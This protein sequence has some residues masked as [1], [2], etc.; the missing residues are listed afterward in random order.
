MK[1]EELEAAIR[2]NRKMGFSHEEIQEIQLATKTFPVD[3]IWDS[4]TVEAVAAWQAANG[5]K[6]DGKVGPS[7]W[8][9]MSLELECVAPGPSQ[10]PEVETGVGCGLAAY[11]IVFPGHTAA[12]SLGTALSS[13]LAEDVSEIRYWSSEWLIDDLGNKGT[14]H[15]EPFL[16]S[17][18]FSSDLRIGA[19][20]DDPISVLKKPVYTSRLASMGI[21]AG[22]LMINRSNTRKSDAPWVLR[23]RN[24]DDLKRVAD[25]FETR[26]IE[27]IATTW[28]RPSKAMIDRMC[29]DMTRIMAL[30]GAVAFEVDTEGNWKPKHLAGFRTMSEAAHYLAAAMRRAIVDAGLEAVA[31]TELTTYTYHTENSAKAVL[32]PLLDFLLPQGYAVRHR[33]HDVIEWDDSLGP[34]RHPK[35]AIARARLAAAA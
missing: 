25:N 5:L 9:A 35:L 14:P 27:R 31:R 11:D 33:E 12:D 30:I 2:F 23:W 6:P 28:P 22:A 16:L 10:T 3:G 7:T 32:A 29:E 20:I 15:G 19:W 17:Q 1:T 24:L 18:R 34:R 13:A 21:N 26:G 4:E 8:G